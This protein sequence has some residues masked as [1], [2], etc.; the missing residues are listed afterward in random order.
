MVSIDGISTHP[1]HVRGEY[2]RMTSNLS[3]FVIVFYLKCKKEKPKKIVFN[4]SKDTIRMVGNNF[5]VL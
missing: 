3:V 2:F 1:A 5:L 4:Y